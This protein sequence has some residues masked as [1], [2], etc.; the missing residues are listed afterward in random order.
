MLDVIE[1]LPCDASSQPKCPRQ[2]KHENRKN[3][4]QKKK[5]RDA[6][7]QFLPTSAA[8]QVLSIVRAPISFKENALIVNDSHNN[9]HI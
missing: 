6:C 8:M 2:Q 5:F 1:P 4:K 9:L 7:I 3:K